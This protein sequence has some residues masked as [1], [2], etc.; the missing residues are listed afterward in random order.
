MFRTIKMYSPYKGGQTLEKVLG[1]MGAFFMLLGIVLQYL[2]VKNS[3]LSGLFFAFCVAAW[4]VPLVELILIKWPEGYLLE[5]DR[6]VFHCK[7]KRNELLYEDI[8]CIIIVNAVVERRGTT[9]KTPW[10]AMIGELQDDILQY[11]INKNK[12]H[13]LRSRDIQWRLGEKIGWFHYEYL[14]KIFK[15]GS[16][17]IYNYGFIWNK[18]E[19]HKVLEGFKGD[20]YIAASVISNYSDEL[21]AVCKQYGIDNQRIHIIDDSINGEFI[22]HLRRKANENVL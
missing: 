7:C 21:N 8:R 9:T 12:K 19:I 3:D 11:L 18:Q 17:T 10:I 13:V 22:W 16:S 4:Y 14:W 20:Y 15:K 1:I 5:K 6:I 2:I